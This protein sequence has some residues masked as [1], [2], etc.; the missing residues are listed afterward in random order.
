MA[1]QLKTSDPNR[2]LKTIIIVVVFLALAF[3]T[4]F[5]ISGN[6]NGLAHQ[7]GFLGTHAHLY[8][9]IN[10]IAQILLLAGMTV[11]FFL[12]HYGKI[13]AHQYNQTT[14]VLFNVVLAICIMIIRFAEDVVSGLP[15]NLRETYAIVGIIHAVLGTLAIV[16][17]IYLL[18]RMNKLIPKAWRVPWW[19]NLMRV[20]LGLYLAT[21]LLG[22]IT[23]F[24]W[25]VFV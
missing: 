12:A 23:Y 21:G 24:V 18:L 5:L 7:P 19:K 10:L 2:L 1:A 17:G 25:N 4:I 11:G 13:D 9:D 22:V 20:T 3:S 8:S 14:W 6:L 15:A 16:C